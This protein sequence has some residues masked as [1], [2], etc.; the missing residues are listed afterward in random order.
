MDR[1]TIS[2]DFID[3][4]SDEGLDSQDLGDAMG[5]IIS[6]CFSNDCELTLKSNQGNTLTAYILFDLFKW[7]RVDQLPPVF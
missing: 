7:D 4:I 5:W 2:S 3:A 1:M 6:E